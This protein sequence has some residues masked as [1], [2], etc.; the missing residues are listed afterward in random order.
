MSD[1][2]LRTDLSLKAEIELY[3]DVFLPPSN[4]PRPLLIAVHGYG[5]HKR[6][7]MREARSVAPDGWAIASV[8][9]PHQHFRQTN[10]GYRVGFGWLTDHRPEE[11]VRL[12]HEFLL[13]VVDALDGEIDRSR[14]YLYGFSQAC[15]L[16]FRFAFTY[17]EVPSGVIGVCGGIPG[18]LETNEV[19]TPFEAPTIYL[20]GDDDEFYSQER[21]ADF[22]RKLGERLPN[23]TSKKF[24]AGHEIT[25]EMRQ[26]IRAFLRGSGA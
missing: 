8:Q 10:D 18:D 4:G 13:R 19:Y 20:Y 17:P 25:E 16:N 6:Y 15:A 1:E 22:D 14:I 2:H 5:A 3:Y 11:Y 9:G 26:D 21:F 12:H 23:Y 24:R 7:M